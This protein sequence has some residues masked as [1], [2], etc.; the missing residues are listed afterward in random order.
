MRMTE[1]ERVLQQAP[2]RPFS[3]P[4]WSLAIGGWRP[5]VFV[6]WHDPAAI[7]VKGRGMPWPPTSPRGRAGRCE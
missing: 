6:P 5:V 7:V 4:T 3:C 1:R 2:P